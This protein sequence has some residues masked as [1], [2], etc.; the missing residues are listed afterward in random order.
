LD[1]WMDRETDRQLMTL[2]AAQTTYYQTAG[3]KNNVLKKCGTCYPGTG[4]QGLEK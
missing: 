3:L 1:G 2:G 4:T